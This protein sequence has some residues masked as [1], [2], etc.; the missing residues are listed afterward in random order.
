MTNPRRP[1]GTGKGRTT[2]QNEQ[3]AQV[4]R[5]LTTAAQMMAMAGQEQREIAEHMASS[6]EG[7][8]YI[9]GGMASGGDPAWFGGSAAPKRRRKSTRGD[10]PKASDDQSTRPT[11]SAPAGPK[12]PRPPQQLP[13]RNLGLMAYQG[14]GRLH[15]GS[16]LGHMRQ[17][18]RSRMGEYIHSTF[19]AGSGETFIPGGQD[20]SGNR[21]FHAYD[22][23]G[24]F[25][26][27]V[28]EAEE[29]VAG[30]VAGAATRARVSGIGGALGGEGAMA[31]LRA[32]PYLGAGAAAVGA[33][34]EGAN[35]VSNQRQA[36][37]QYQSIL[38]GS[39]MGGM[40]QRFLQAGFQLS[41][42]FG[43]GL[44]WGESGKAFKDVTALGYQGGN[45]QQRLNF[46]QTNYKHTGMSV[47]QSMELIGIAAKGVTANFSELE[48]QLQ[49]V[50][51]A[52]KDTGQ[53]AA[54][55]RENFIQN[56]GALQQASQ[57]ANSG[58][59]AQGLTNVTAGLGRAYAPL[60]FTGM[61]DQAGMMRAASSMGYGN[62]AQYEAAGQSN[63]MV[64]AQGSQNVINQSLGAVVPQDLKAY[65]QQLIQQHGGNQAVVNNQNL[66]M[67]IA[68][69]AM[70]SGKVQIQSIR[71]VLTAARVSGADKMSDQAV[72]A[73]IVA[74]VAGGV[75]LTKQT[76]VQ[77]SM[78]QQQ[79]VGTSFWN[80]NQVKN[81]GQGL[82]DA[83]RKKLQQDATTAMQGI[84]KGTL[85]YNQQQGLFDPVI[86]RL[87]K[88]FGT[89][90]QLE[91]QTARGS[92]I[93]T[94][95]QA[96]K[97]Y[98]DQLVNGS[99]IIASGD[100]KGKS[101]KDIVGFT[102]SNAKY[103]DTTQSK[104]DS[105]LLTKKGGPGWLGT[106]SWDK[107]QQ[108]INQIG[109]GGTAATGTGTSTGVYIDM[110]PELKKY[111][112]ITV[113]GDPTVEAGAASGAP[114]KA[115]R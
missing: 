94:L 81:I 98:R 112:N 69:Q 10:A 22:T 78:G 114:P 49:K 61:F 43:G 62:L 37:S 51:K 87:Q 113:T 9:L 67:V 32:V 50:S 103:G 110:S 39:N 92:Q 1:R 48:D 11:H 7:L 3:M 35:F 73:Y 60:N 105:A 38:G 75:D 16:Y 97:D 86:D 102:E 65:I 44:S 106:M 64:T 24:R 95:A 14:A 84:G 79:K 63:P 5:D 13:Q 40:G 100:Q 91:V 82:P 108:Q 59:L 54:A 90:L 12:A 88:Q 20:Q 17:T 74:W 15:G 71:G 33:L 89:G 23:T 80:D 52:A 29:G 55:L 21:L 83:D 85:A 34:W 72:V 58:Q 19:G 47:D 57:G 101:V 66:Q 26:G 93:V 25:S 30:R 107:M 104:T 70:A 76:A 28:S 115:S 18:M 56:Y 46:A 45:R 36:N 41:S 27:T 111:L 77:Q 99:A 2:A 6:Q 68:Q 8:D 31:G 96:A 42:L 109:G 53:N 4:L